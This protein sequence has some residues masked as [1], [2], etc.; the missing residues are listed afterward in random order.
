MKDD[1]TI[2]H[3]NVWQVTAMFDDYDVQNY[4]WKLAFVF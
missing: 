3:C 2:S 1:I 4:F